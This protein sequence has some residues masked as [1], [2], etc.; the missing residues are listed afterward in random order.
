[1][2]AI[3]LSLALLPFSSYVYSPYLSYLYQTY[4]SL[5]DSLISVNNL[6]SFSQQSIL[7]ISTTFF[8]VLFSSFLIFPPWSICAGLAYINF[9]VTTCILH[10]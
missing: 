7:S 5:T 6:P 10:S 2:L 3:S 9:I 4:H 1:M 8:N